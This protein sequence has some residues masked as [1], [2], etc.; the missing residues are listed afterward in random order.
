MTHEVGKRLTAKVCGGGR[1]LTIA[2]MLGLL[3]ATVAPGEANSI[4]EYTG[5]TFL[6]GTGIDGTVNFAVFTSDNFANDAA[7]VL[8][9]FAPGQSSPSALDLSPG[10]YVYAFQIANNGSNTSSITSA[11]FGK[12]DGADVTS[13]GYFKNG[14]VFTDQNG[15]VS[16]TN[17]L[18][19]GATSVGFSVDSGISPGFVKNNTTALTVGLINIPN[20]ATSSLL[21]YT[22]SYGP[23]WLSTQINSGASG[24]APGADPPV[25]VPE[26]GTLILTMLGVV[27]LGG[28]WRRGSTPAIRR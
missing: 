24:P 13:W 17:N 19:V 23:D 11:S 10:M 14:V 8:A 27:G 18:D 20:G 15:L 7:G 12:W 16:S 26:P 2:L 22:S 5:N 9:S 21:V 3:A 25:G 1:L 28:L 4:A 6:S